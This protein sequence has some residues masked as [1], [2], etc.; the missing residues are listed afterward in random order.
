M[1]TKKLKNGV[2]LFALVESKQYDMI[3]A[4]AFQEHKSIAEIVRKALDMYIKHRTKKMRRNT[5]DKDSHRS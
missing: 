5:K 4:F 2:T 1:A 3:R